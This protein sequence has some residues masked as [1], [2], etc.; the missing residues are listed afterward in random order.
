MLSVGTLLAF[1]FLAVDVLMLRYLPINECPLPLKTLAEE[2]DN[3]YTLLTSADNQNTTETVS[4]QNINNIGKL[5][6]YFADWSILRYL[7]ERSKYSIPMIAIGT[8]CVSGILFLVI[9]L[10]ATDYLVEYTW[11]SLLII[12]FFG[13][14]TL[15]SF[16][17]LLL[18]EHN[19]SFTSFQVSARK[20]NHCGRY[21]TCAR[22]HTYTYACVFH[23]CSTHT[24]TYTHTHTHTHTHSHVPDRNWPCRSDTIHELTFPISNSDRLIIKLCY[25]M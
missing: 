14:F 17:V 12:T 5:R 21:Y 22:A 25:C 7:S 18:H 20:I 19:T 23:Y 8:M 24:H 1:S 16:V 11:W 3:K 13:L 10:R 9:L 6:P 2:Y 15:L 4:K